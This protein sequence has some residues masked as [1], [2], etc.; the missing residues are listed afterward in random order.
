MN[1]PTYKPPPPYV[2][3]QLKQSRRWIETS[4][5][6]GGPALFV[7]DDNYEGLDLAGAS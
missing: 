6:E 7:E 4:L 5:R 2:V 3:R 1:G